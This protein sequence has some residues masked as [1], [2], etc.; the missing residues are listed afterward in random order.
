MEGALVTLEMA[1]NL[2]APTLH[3]EVS[4]VYVDIQYTRLFASIERAKRPT[5]RSE[6]RALMSTEA[7][8]R[9]LLGTEAP[10]RALMGTEALLLA[11]SNLAAPT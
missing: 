3:M 7:P 4:G 1:K 5:E 2:E 10:L 9:A 11:H 6:A 8:L